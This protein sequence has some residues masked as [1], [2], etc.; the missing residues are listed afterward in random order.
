MPHLIP[1]PWLSVK[2]ISRPHRAVR[3][4]VPCPNAGYL[5]SRL[6]RSSHWARH[7]VPHVRRPRASRALPTSS[8]SLPTTWG[9]RDIGCFGTGAMGRPKTPN[10]DRMAAEGIRFTDFYVAQAVC[11]ASRAAL[12]TGVSQPRRHSGRLGPA[13]ANGLHT[14]RD[15]ARRGAEA[16]GYATAIF[17][18]WH[19]G[20]PPAVPADAARLRRVLRPAVLERH[21]AQAPAA[22]A[23]SPTCR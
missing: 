21:V 22:N 9:T 17:G 16:R 18:K 15:D 4:R 6:S 14:I 10:L 1:P 20:A 3:S 2:H 23:S 7:E 13:A 12:L 5:R 8:S 11:S 19:L